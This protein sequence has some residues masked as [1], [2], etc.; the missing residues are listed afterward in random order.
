GELE[1]GGL[2]FH[3][4][5]DRAAAD[6][7]DSMALDFGDSHQGL[8]V[9]GASPSE[10]VAG[11]HA[12]KRVLQLRH[13]VDA[14]HQVG[15]MLHELVGGQIVENSSVDQRHLVAEDWTRNHRQVDAL[16]HGMND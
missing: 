7:V 3:E 1:G 8:H 15:P 2:W 13:D 11:A 14:D 10:R 4:Q 5:V 9:P 6:G 12:G 16:E